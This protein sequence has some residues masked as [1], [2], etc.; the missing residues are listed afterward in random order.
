MHSAFSFIVFFSFFLCLLPFFELY[1]QEHYNLSLVYL[2]KLINEVS[3]SFIESAK[4]T[5]IISQDPENR[6]IEE[7]LKKSQI[8]LKLSE[9]QAMLNQNEQAQIIFWCGD[10]SNQE[11]KN[12]AKKCNQNKQISVCDG[13]YPITSP[14]CLD[15]ID[16]RETGVHLGHNNVLYNYLYQG[17]IGATIKSNDFCKV[18]VFPIN[19]EIP[20]TIEA[21][22]N[23]I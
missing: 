15:Y 17:V 18:F 20:Y 1:K 4:T 9:K 2:D 14:V 22:Q 8:L 10:L 23:E 16:F 7:K 21:D 3:G 13:C 12:Y 19:Y 11:V 5:P 6:E